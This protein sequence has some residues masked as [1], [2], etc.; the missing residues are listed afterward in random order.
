MTMKP[1]ETQDV[2]LSMYEAAFDEA[3]SQFYLPEEQLQ[4]TALPNWVLDESLRDP[5]RYPVV[6]LA[7]QTP[8][9]FFVLHKGE[10]GSDYTSNPHALLLRAFSVTEAHQG[11]GYAKKAML[12]LPGFVA[13]HLPGIDEI[14][15]VV[16]ERNLA[17][18][19]LYEKTGFVD[20]GI[21][22]MGP[23]GRQFMLHF[24]L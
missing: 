1:L 24:S 20:K 4:F 14:I 22:R 2:Q 21:R 23:I 10:G 12:A 6:I 16:N 8:V 5:D 17:A 15:L 7:D 11:K 9:G 13:D 18:K 19:Q 3:L